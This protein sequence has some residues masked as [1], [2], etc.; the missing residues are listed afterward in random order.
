MSPR[1]EDGLGFGP[2][3]SRFGV[4]ALIVAHVTRSAC[5]EPALVGD[6]GVVPGRQASVERLR[7]VRAETRTD[8]QIWIHVTPIQCAF[9]HPAMA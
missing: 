5:A 8:N 7:F 1:A 2:E 3:R 9:R 6:H 4:R